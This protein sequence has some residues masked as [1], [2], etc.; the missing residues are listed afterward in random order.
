MN[1]ILANIAIGL[2]VFLFFV[3]FIALMIFFIAMGWGLFALVTN[4][5]RE[6]FSNKI[7][8][9]IGFLT[10]LGLIGVFY[11]LGYIFNGGG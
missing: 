7:Q 4:V 1:N 8:M 3:T 10:S 2:V 6:D 5:R 11:T 9:L